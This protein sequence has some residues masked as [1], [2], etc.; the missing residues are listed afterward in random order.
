[1]CNLP[2]FLVY[3]S[4]IPVTVGKIPTQTHDPWHMETNGDTVIA[5]MQ[6]EEQDLCPTT[7]SSLSFLFS[8]KWKENKTKPVIDLLRGEIIKQD[9][10][11]EILT[12][13][14]SVSEWET[15]VIRIDMII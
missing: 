3:P 14:V 5:A 11:S 12:A 7:R 8:K 10:F 4:L 15:P 9:T 2:P 13:V 1:M 6:I